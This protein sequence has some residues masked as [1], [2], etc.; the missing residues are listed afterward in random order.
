[1][2]T[3]SPTRTVATRLSGFT[4]LTALSLFAPAGTLRWWNGWLFM[5]LGVALVGML[6]GIV[7]RKSPDLVQE[8][9]TAAGRAKA[10]DRVL[11]PIL[12]VVLP[13]T[14]NIL[15]GLDRRFGWTTALDLPHHLAGLLA[16]LAGMLLTFRAMQANR[17]FS[18]HVRIQHDRGHTVVSDGPYRF[19]RHPGYA[20]TILYNLGAPVMLGSLVAFSVGIAMAVLFVV[21]TVFEDRVLR[22]ELPGYPE[23]AARVHY[24][25][26]P[27]VW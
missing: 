5:G 1:M 22:R 12:A 17:F 20:G 23:Y 11:V 13:F 18:S 27:L 4:L 19:V 21:R 16:M 3:K 25:L 10:W 7:F 6:T 9:M 24:R 26:L 14:S 2:A 8:R 15:A